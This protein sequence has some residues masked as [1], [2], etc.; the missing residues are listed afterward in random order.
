MCVCQQ[1]MGKQDR[2]R[3]LHVR[4][5]GH[6]RR[7]MRGRLGGQ[8]AS[9]VEHPIGD[10]ACGVAQPQPKQRG[11]LVV[12]GPP[13]PQPP[14]QILTDPVDQA[15]LQRAVHIL[16]GHQRPETAVRD[17]LGQAVQTGD[18]IVALPLGQQLGS[19]EH[20]RVRL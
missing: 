20:P 18:Q 14:S 3:G 13:G 7:R 6:D 4:L 2:L 10:P 12:S 16:V 8:R 9:D 19:K 5:T 11:H 17:V 15:A 1:M